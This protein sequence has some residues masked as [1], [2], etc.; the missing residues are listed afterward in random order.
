MIRPFGQIISIAR[1]KLQLTQKEVAAQLKVPQCTISAWETGRQTPSPRDRDGIL[2]HT[3]MKILSSYLK[4]DLCE[5]KETL[6][7]QRVEFQPS[8]GRGM[9]SSGYLIR[10][11]EYLEKIAYNVDIWV[12]NPVQLTNADL[13]LYRSDLS[14]F[15]NLGVSYHLIWFL[16]LVDPGHFMSMPSALNI[17]FEGSGKIIHYA[18]SRSTYFE[19]NNH[20]LLPNCWATQQSNLRFYEKV[21]KQSANKG[22]KYLPFKY[23]EDQLSH[24]LCNW[25]AWYQMVFIFRPRSTAFKSLVSNCFDFGSERIWFIAENDARLDLEILVDEF[26]RVFDKTSPTV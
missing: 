24:N 13:N 2:Y 19:N 9:L 25:F 23:V 11:S 8:S 15:L 4:I 1:K 18:T 16:D 3:K 6:V 22:Q 17:S 5:L 21:Q 10:M 26:Q 20:L 7:Q 14:F 12:L